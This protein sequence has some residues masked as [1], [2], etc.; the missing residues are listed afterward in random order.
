MK[1]LLINKY[2]YLKGGAERAY[3]D[4]AEILRK[5]GH[6]VAFFSTLNKQNV[7]CEWSHYFVEAADLS[8]GSHSVMEKIKITTKIWYNFEAR[9]QLRDLIKDFRPDVAHLHN[10]Y[11]QLSPS[12]IDELK[13]QGVPMVMTLHDYKLVSP[14]YNLFV[15]GQIWQPHSN[16]ECLKSHCVKNS[17][18]KSLICVIEAKLHRMLGVYA[19]VDCYVSP[20]KFLI[21]KFVELGFK[22]NI[23][24]LPNPIINLKQEKQT[25]VKKSYI[26]FFGRLSEEKGVMDLIEAYRQIKT[27]VRLVIVGSGPEQARIEAFIKKWN[28]SARLKMLG[29]LSGESLWRQV[30]LAWAV[31]VPS[32]WYENAPYSVIEAQNLGQVVVAPR[33]GGM[34][35]QIKDGKSGLLYA[36]D[37]N[38]SLKIALDR[39][40]A[41]TISQR[42]SIGRE[43][44]AGVKKLNSEEAYYKALNKIYKSLI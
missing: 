32:K 17:Y 22:Q 10:I 6:E 8:I 2:H 26:L 42:F 35:E 25:K 19:K 7:P 43:A 39:A 37:N 41:L 24:Y 38:E 23:K 29:H 30:A 34:T 28:L 40:L 33:L 13:K 27:K 9:R 31:V 14:N 18:A 11:H 12:V 1:I 36:S 4:Q 21:D 16:C 3:F 5:Q 15:D 20:S 44:I